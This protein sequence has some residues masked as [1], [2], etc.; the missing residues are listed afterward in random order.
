MRII[1][2]LVLALVLQSAT[3][4]ANTLRFADTLRFDHPSVQ[5]VRHISQVLRERTNGRLHL[6]EVETG[7]PHSE[8]FLVAQVW[9]GRLDMARVSLNAL[10]GIAPVSVIPTTVSG[11]SWRRK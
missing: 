11:G 7:V 1:L 5:S 2:A 4:L 6:G 8:S 3:A 10:N 9:M